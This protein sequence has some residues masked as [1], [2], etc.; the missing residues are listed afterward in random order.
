MPS[1]CAVIPKEILIIT[2]ALLIPFDCW[3]REAAAAVEEGSGCSLLGPDTA[4][5]GG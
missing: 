4:S 3:D 2:E 5:Q 1:T